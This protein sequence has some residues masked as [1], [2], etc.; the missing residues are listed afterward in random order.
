MFSWST[1][2]GNMLQIIKRDFK[3]RWTSLIAYSVGA[4][5]FA[6]LYTS[7][8]GSVQ[9]SQEQLAK[10]YKAFP[11]A[12]YEAFGIQDLVINTLPKFLG[13]ELFSFMWPILAIFLV[14]SR[15][16]GSITGEVEKGTLGLYLALPITRSKLYWSK[17]LSSLLAIFVFVVVSIG[18]I[19]PIAALFDQEISASVILHLA[20][21]GGLFMWAVYAFTIWI[22]CIFSEKS[23]VY[24]F[25][26]SFLAVMYV[27]NV[28]AGLQSSLA[29]LH[30]YSVFYYF[31]SQ[32]V[33]NKNIIDSSSFLVFGVT[34][35][36]FSILGMLVFRRR[37]IY[38]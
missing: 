17:Y 7:I 33:L 30:N 25:V 14:I 32:D 21:L 4:L 28:V 26:G 13:L 8:Y 2:R 23:K 18:G 19:I 5:S 16:A 15:A 37:D 11:K 34:I 35:V 9:Q 29:W 36:L 22:A 31:N 6:M 3:D 24:M 27:I 20:I 10:L 1:T 12:L 38:V